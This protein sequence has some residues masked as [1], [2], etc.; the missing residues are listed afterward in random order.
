MEDM[1]HFFKKVQKKVEEGVQDIQDGVQD[2]QKKVQNAFK[3]EESKFPGQGV[4][5][6]T[7]ADEA[8]RKDK[9]EAWRRQQQASSSS[10]SKLSAPAP[11]AST[12]PAPIPTPTASAPAFQGPAYRLGSF[13]AGG[14]GSS[15][16]APAPSAAA[17]AASRAATL[18]AKVSGK[19]FAQAA[20]NTPPAEVPP[21]SSTE[22][23]G[24]SGG[25]PASAGSPSTLGAPAVRAGREAAQRLLQEDKEGADEEGDEELL[26]AVERSIEQMIYTKQNDWSSSIPVLVK[27]LAKVCLEPHNPK[28]RRLRLTN[29]R[30]QAQVM[31]VHGALELLQA[32]GFELRFEEMPD[33]GGASE[34]IALLPPSAPLRP[35][36]AAS[37]FLAALSLAP[38]PHPALPQEPFGPA[39]RNLKVLQPAA[40]C[41]AANF[42]PDEDYLSFSGEELKAEA[43]A[44]RARLEESRIMSTRAFKEK[45]A[46]LRK[47]PPPSSACVRVRFAT[48]TILQGDFS[49]YEPV[50]AVFEFVSSCLAEPDAFELLQCGRPGKGG[51]RGG[52]GGLNMSLQRTAPNQDPSLPTRAL[53]LADADL[54][55]SALLT[56]KWTDL[57]KQRDQLLRSDLKRQEVLLE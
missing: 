4:V 7:K 45:Q 8:K 46:R 55:P 6:G 16:G 34:G 19:P 52:P 28:V 22:G 35:L 41:S 5:I 31:D 2:A 33:Q 10:S 11:P 24:V 37:A 30:I 20:R 3:T 32:V 53:T 27:L 17:A 47:G 18:Q 57:Q 38:P 40:Q 14:Y 54:V 56:F 48:G 25:R 1:K 21:A 13:T 49:A 50:A 36:C 12:I 23:R 15:S 29:P 51:A 39:N 9:E 43:L 26:H 42:M 44:R